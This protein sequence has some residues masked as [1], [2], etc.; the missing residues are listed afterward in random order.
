MRAQRCEPLDSIWLSLCFAVC[1]RGLSRSPILDPWGWSPSSA[2]LR[3]CASLCS[4]AV[5]ITPCICGRILLWSWGHRGG[6]WTIASRWSSRTYSFTRWLIAL[7]S[8]TSIATVR[9][10]D[11]T[12]SRGRWRCGPDRSID[13]RRSSRP[14]SP[15][16]ASLLS[17]RWTWNSRIWFI[18]WTGTWIWRLMLSSCCVTIIV[19]PGSLTAAF[20]SCSQ[21]PLPCRRRR[22]SRLSPPSPPHSSWISSRWG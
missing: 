17:A 6:T 9:I 15:V 12:S 8:C 5:V 7:D 20:R 18:C 1:L 3:G 19:L 14:T 10:C 2:C 13:R 22:W 16:S 4:I 21:A 11:C